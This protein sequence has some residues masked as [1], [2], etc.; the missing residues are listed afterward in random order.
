MMIG[1]ERT[2]G[3]AM[4][5]R[6][7]LHMADL[8]QSGKIIETGDFRLDLSRRVA[9]VRGKELSLTTAEFDV[10]LFLTSHPTN[11]VTSSTTLITNW[12]GRELR[13]AEFLHILLSL[14]QKI[15]AT[16]GANGYL[17]T[18]SVVFCRFNP[19]GSTRR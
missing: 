8:R 1:M 4:A 14:C 18:E 10:L 6:K 19:A 11:V 7:E 5:R 15:T 3:V 9:A 12:D 16:C 17:N 13:K 2:A